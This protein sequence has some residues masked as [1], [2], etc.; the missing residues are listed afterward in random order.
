MTN[1]TYTFWGKF[2]NKLLEKKYIVYSTPE[3]QERNRVG[4][5]ISGVIFFLIGFTDFFRADSTINLYVA[6]F[7]R[8]A[9]FLYSIWIYIT[10]KK[11]RKITHV[12]FHVYVYAL[13]FTL[14][15]NAIIFLLNSSG[16]VEV[17]DL[18]TLPITILLVYVFVYLYSLYLLTVGVLAS[19][20]YVAHLTLYN[21]LSYVEIS[22]LF[23]IMCGVN[24]LG[25]YISRFFNMI[26]R[27]EFLRII[28]IEKLNMGLKDEIEERRVIQDKLIHAYSE[29]TDGMR[30]ANHLQLAMLSD[31][32]VLKKY[33]RE[34]FVLYKPCDIVSGD[35]YW[36][37][38]VNN[39]IIIV[40]ADCTGHGIRAAFMSIVGITFLDDI[41][42]NK[43]VTEAH[44]ILNQ[45]KD[46][47][48]KNFRQ[49]GT[50]YS[51]HDGMDI[52][53]CVVDLKHMTMQYAG[54]YNPLL[55][56]RKGKLIEYKADRMPI[57]YYFA[58]KSSFTTHTIS[59]QPNDM[60]YLFTDG[61]ADQFGGEKDKKY[62]YKR[63]KRELVNHAHLSLSAQYK[64]LKNTHEEW[65][66]QTPQTDDIV[67]LGFKIP[68]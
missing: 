9:T 5:F 43:K 67:F 51:S 10:W 31:P 48:V 7:L 56:I 23:L 15:L 20:V 4:I 68:V 66:K 8:S 37:S 54:A 39:K 42:H 36:F 25:F 6:V 2:F 41:V 35:F 16:R 32:S 3:I 33:F 52:S 1:P 58:A 14:F 44:E 61:Y 50:Y 62:T 19:L 30:Y 45:L 21:N 26:R 53:L 17:I 11:P 59:I 57:S 63:L 64:F 46:Q 40:S 29:L 27:G 49:G 47:V 18:L 65:R 28:E 38:Q 60:C 55:I 12:H 34:Y 24:V 13:V 22:I